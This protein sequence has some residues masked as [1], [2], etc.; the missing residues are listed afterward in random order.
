MSLDRERLAKLLGMIGSS[1]DAEALSAARRANELVHEAKMTWHE[2]LGQITSNGTK[3][4]GSAKPNDRPSRDGAGAIIGSS[5]AHSA[6]RKSLNPHFDNPYRSV[7]IK[8]SGGAIMS[9]KQPLPTGSQLTA[10]DPV[11]R[12]H[13]HQYLDRLPFTMMRSSGGSS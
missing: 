10:L 9:N 1:F 4:N 13:P 6:S 3:S 11:F 8:A 7:R 2:V 5:R 12:E